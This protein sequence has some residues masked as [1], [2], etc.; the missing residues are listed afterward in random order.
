MALN[1]ILILLPNKFYA[2]DYQS[3]IARKRQPSKYHSSHY[4]KVR[5]YTS[6]MS[7]VVLNDY[8]IHLPWYLSFM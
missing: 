8:H 7:D 2:R 6:E 5:K 4:G 3:S 1:M